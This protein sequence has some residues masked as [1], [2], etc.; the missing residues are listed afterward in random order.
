MTTR[1]KTCLGLFVRDSN[2][3]IHRIVSACLPYVHSWVIVDCSADT[4]RQRML[5]SL[6]RNLPG[7]YLQTEPLPLDQGFNRLMQR[8]AGLSDDVLLLCGDESVYDLFLHGAPAGETIGFL[9]VEHEGYTLSLPRL[10]PNSSDYRFVGG[11][12]AILAYPHEQT[13]RQNPIG[14]VLKKE[15]DR[16]DDVVAADIESLQK[17]LA[18]EHDLATSATLKLVLAR[19][20]LAVASIGDAYELLKSVQASGAGDEQVWQATYLAANVELSVHEDV[21]LAIASFESCLK[22]D[23]GRGEPHARLAEIYQE[24]GD[25]D[26]AKQHT[27]ALE[28]LAPPN[29][30]QFYE[31]SVYN[32]APARRSLPTP[33]KASPVTQ[34]GNRRSGMPTKKLTLGM[35]TYDDFHGVYFTVMSLVLYHDLDPQQVE[36]LVVDNNPDSAHGQSVA[37]LCNR[38]KIARYVAA[39][40][41]KGTAI[42]EL[43]FAE[44]EGEFVVCMDCHVF[45]HEGTV[46]RLLEYITDNA[47][48]ENLYHGPLVNDEQT[49]FS[50]HM[51]PKWNQGFF[52]VWKSDPRG[53]EVDAEPFEIPMQGLG[54]FACRRAAWPGFNPRFRGFGGEEGYIHEKFRQRGGSVICLPFL[55]WT[56]RFDRPDGTGYRNKWEDRIRN[57]LLGAEELG[58]DK[59]PAIEHFSQFLNKKTV[60]DVR[61]DLVLE[62]QSPF[63]DFDAIYHL[64]SGA[65]DATAL[66]V[67]GIAQVAR[68]IEVRDGRLFAAF[69]HALKIA[70]LQ[71]LPE[72]MLITDEGVN[73]PA[74]FI[75]VSAAS[76]QRNGADVIFGSAESGDRGLPG[77]VLC[78]QAEFEDIRSALKHGDWDQLLTAMQEG[79]KIVTEINQASAVTA[80]ESSA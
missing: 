42:R 49:M 18:N 21:P 24:G 14:C 54:L 43:I 60:A 36:I 7:E 48:S 79:G 62:Q 11:N 72:I 38:V 50:T 28:D 27:Q 58:I 20:L 55:R 80:H 5:E 51:E 10:I 66:N 25:D 2:A 1:N 33:H 29:G 35:A 70:L 73:D 41:V 44:A 77:F 68:H 16:S 9:D 63:W 74:I 53:R 13:R 40:E 32:Q 6:L 46:S 69:R 34:P 4:D 64:C 39:G 61:A 52:G 30:V 65:K 57:Y 17:A 78:K 15:A 22:L 56:H 47:D 37:S 71:G 67:L 23:A 19:D 59:Q 31:Q 3:E 75:L 8:A 26:A 76:E 12:H 45:L